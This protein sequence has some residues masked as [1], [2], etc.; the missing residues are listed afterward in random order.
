MVVQKEDE[1]QARVRR[2]PPK[3]PPPHLRVRS[4]LSASHGAIVSHPPPPP[5]DPRAAGS[6]TI[7]GLQGSRAQA[8]K[9]RQSILSGFIYAFAS[10]FF[11][12]VVYLSTQSELRVG[13]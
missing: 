7:A 13:A 10:L 3:I 12:I 6:V 9:Q 1:Q 5:P 4:T 2:A 11:I 8:R